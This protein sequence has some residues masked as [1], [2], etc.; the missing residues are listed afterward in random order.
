VG[1]DG[2]DQETAKGER[3]RKEESG[4]WQKAAEDER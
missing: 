4:E 3:E 2:G 1:E